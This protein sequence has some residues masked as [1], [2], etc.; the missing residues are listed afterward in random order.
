[1][2]VTSDHRTTLRCDHADARGQCR[3]TFATDSPPAVAIAAARQYGW[4]VARIVGGWHVSCQRHRRT[5]IQH[6]YA[7]TTPADR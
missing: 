1:M 4:A 3:S 6:G 5:A 7:F 2:P